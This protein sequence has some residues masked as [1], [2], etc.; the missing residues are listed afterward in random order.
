[1]RGKSRQQHV[2]PRGTIKTTFGETTKF[3]ETTTTTKKSAEKKKPNGC[4]DRSANNNS[5]PPSARSFVRELLT[6]V[7]SEPDTDSLL[8][9]S[10]DLKQQSRLMLKMIYFFQVL[11]FYLLQFCSGMGV[12]K[13]EV[14]QYIVYTGT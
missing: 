9:R 1:V 11:P 13:R 7:L 3:G 10:E 5:E 12:G 6:A 4:G 14:M 2:L 8:W